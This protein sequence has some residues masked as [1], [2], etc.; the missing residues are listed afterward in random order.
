MIIIKKIIIIFNLC[1]LTG[2]KFS[3][4]WDWQFENKKITKGK[5]KRNNIIIY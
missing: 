1:E 4:K 5:K 3:T 2:C